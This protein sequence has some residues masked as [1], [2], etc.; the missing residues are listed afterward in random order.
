MNYRPVAQP[1]RQQPANYVY[2]ESRLTY[3]ELAAWQ[4]SLKTSHGSSTSDTMIIRNV[5]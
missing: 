3:R 1:R 5:L 2:V 4:R